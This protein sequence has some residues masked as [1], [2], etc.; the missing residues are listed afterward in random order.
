MGTLLYFFTLVLEI[1]SLAESRPYFSRLASWLSVPRDLCPLPQYWS[2]VCTPQACIWMLE[3]W[4]Q[5]LMLTLQTLYP[6]SH[7]QPYPLLYDHLSICTL[8]SFLSCIGSTFSKTKVSL[9][10][11]PLGCRMP[12]KK[13]VNVSQQRAFQDKNALSV[14]THSSEMG[15]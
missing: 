2:Y 12:E 10:F 13:T 6:L 5:V 9:F 3:T 1:R 15:H 4:T 8:S 7:P 14:E 11:L